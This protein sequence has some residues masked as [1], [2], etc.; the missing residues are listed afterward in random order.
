MTFKMY[1]YT[2]LKNVINKSIT[3]VGEVTGVFKNDTDLI[4]PT[5]V[6][7]PGY[8]VTNKN[9]FLIDGLYYFVKEVTRSQERLTV[10]LD[11]D[12]LESYKSSILANYAVLDRSTNKFNA[13][14]VDRD[15]PMINS[16]EITVTKF[17]NGFSGESL[18]LTVSGG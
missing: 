8:E 9:Y 13:Y 14:Q 18:I 10:Q 17:P 12:E 5:L 4:E 3:Y 16:N 2:G 1:T 15:I 6:L 11:L 7:A